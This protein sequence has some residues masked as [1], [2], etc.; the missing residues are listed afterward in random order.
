[1]SDI[2]LYYFLYGYDYCSYLIVVS[3]AQCWKAC[4]TVSQFR[5][6]LNRHEVIAP[7]QRTQRLQQLMRSNIE[8]TTPAKV[9]FRRA[10]VLT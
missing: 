10:T 8:F 5:E 2:D 9:R 1:V 7:W 6:Q 4:S 3:N